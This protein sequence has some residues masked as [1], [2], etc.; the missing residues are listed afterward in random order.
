MSNHKLHN[1]DSANEASEYGSVSKALHCA[2]IVCH[3]AHCVTALSTILATTFHHLFTLLKSLAT[4]S[5]FSKPFIHFAMV[6]ELLAIFCNVVL[7]FNNLTHFS[8]WFNNLGAVHHIEAAVARISGARLAMPS[9][10]YSHS[11]S[12]YFFTVLFIFPSSVSINFPM[13]AS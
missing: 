7:P 1:A 6:L 3:T 11:C 10:A 4:A 12:T 8:I 13:E 9:G 5:I 2:S